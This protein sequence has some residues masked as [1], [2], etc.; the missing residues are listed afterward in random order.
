[1][2][3]MGA[4]LALT[5]DNQPVTPTMCLVTQCSDINPV[6][7][8]DPQ[9]AR[10]IG[11]ATQALSCGATG[12]LGKSVPGTPTSLIPEKRGVA[13]IPVGVRVPPDLRCTWAQPPGLNWHW[14][15]IF[16]EAGFIYSRT[17][18]SSLRSS[19]EMD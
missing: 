2:T 13:T 8:T 19:V 15:D 16:R 4:F 9:L 11:A 1:M 3:S 14:G 18:P 17:E 5:S 10:L 12:R 6:I 7:K